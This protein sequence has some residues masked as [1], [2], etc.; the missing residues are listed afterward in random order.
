VARRELG[1]RGGVDGRPE[2]H[3][4]T[5]RD[6]ERDL[7]LHDRPRQPELGIPSLNIPPRCGSRSKIV[8][9]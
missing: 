1:E 5:A 2:P 7:L 3:V 9:A 8:T 6:D 4:D